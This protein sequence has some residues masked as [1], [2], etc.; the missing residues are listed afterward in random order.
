MKTFKIL[1]NDLVIENGNLLMVEGNDEIVQATERI[2][3]TNK[4]EFFLD[5]NL[6]LEYKQIQGK[7]V[8]EDSIRFAILEAINQDIRV[9]EVD[10]VNVNINRRDRELTVDFRYFTVDGVIEGNEVIIIG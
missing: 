2:L 7:N 5:I 9:L 4:N 6:G 8:D 3:T 10:F 1:N